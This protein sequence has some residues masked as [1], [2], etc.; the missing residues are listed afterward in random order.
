MLLI[1]VCWGLAQLVVG[2]QAQAR[3][4]IVGVLLLVVIGAGVRARQVG[5]AIAGA[6]LF[7]LL[8]TQA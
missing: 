1:Q 7:A 2:L 5:L 8:M 4:G 3:L 6:V